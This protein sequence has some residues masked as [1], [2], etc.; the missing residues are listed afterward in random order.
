MGSSVMELADNHEHLYS[1]NTHWGSQT[2]ALRQHLVPGLEIGMKRM[3]CSYPSVGGRVT[4]LINPA[5][6]LWGNMLY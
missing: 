1:I 2:H 5:A 6:T 3:L 4:G